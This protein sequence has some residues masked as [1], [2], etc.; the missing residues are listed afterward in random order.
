M[1]NS[2]GITND[3]FKVVNANTISKN[4][5]ITLQSSVSV[6]KIGDFRVPTFI[7][8]AKQFIQIWPVSLSK[9]ISYYEC[10]LLIPFVKKGS[11]KPKNDIDIS[12][13]T[14][15]SYYVQYCDQ[16]KQLNKD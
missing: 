15:N 7:F 12:S 5:Q 10:V 6:G 13:Y 8:F 4:K 2:L 1:V 9:I 11:A 16:I 14:L 3:K